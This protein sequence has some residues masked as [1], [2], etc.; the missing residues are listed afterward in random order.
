MSLR[1]TSDLVNELEPAQVEPAENSP[2]DSHVASYS[3]RVEPA[4]LEFGLRPGES[5]LE[6]AQ[7][8][9]I[10][11]P[12]ICKGQAS[13][14]TCF[15]KILQGYENIPKAQPAETE[16]L[17]TARRVEPGETRLACQVRP[18]GDLT[19]NKKAIRKLTDGRPQ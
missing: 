12:S 11:W 19:V 2:P 4:G 1:T 7:R 13:C 14:T 3:V 9:N 15:I 17:A 10:R 6:A 5:V 8:N 16:A 18:T